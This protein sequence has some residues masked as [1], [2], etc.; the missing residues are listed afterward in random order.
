MLA[1]KL[2]KYILILSVFVAANVLCETIPGWEHESLKTPGKYNSGVMLDGIQVIYSSPVI[3]NIDND[4]SNG[5]ET[6]TVTSDGFVNA[7]NSAGQI[8]WKA[9]LPNSKCTLASSDD[10]GYSSPAIGEI[11]GDGIKYVVVGYGGVFAKDCG[12]GVVAINAKTGKRKWLFDLKKFTKKNKIP[13]PIGYA[14]FSTPVLGDIDNDG[15]LEIAFG[16]FDRNIY[17]LNFKGRPVWYYHAADTVW[18]SGAFHD[19]NGDGKQEL[20]IGTDI[21]ENKNYKPQTY[22]GG[23]VYAL[24]VKVKKKRTK[25]SNGSFK[26]VYVLLKYTFR[27]KRAYLWQTAFSQTIFSSPSLA[28]LIPENPG[29]E[30][31]VGTGCYFPESSKNKYGKEVSILSAATGEIIKKLKTSVCISSSP[32]IGD[33]NSDG[34]PDIALAVP[35]SSSVGGDGDSRIMAYD[36]RTGEQLWETI[37]LYYTMNDS[38]AGNFSSPIIADI[39]GNGSNE[40]IAANGEGIIIVNGVDGEQLTCAEQTCSTARLPT[41]GI[42]RNTPAVGDIDQD[43]DLELVAASGK[44][45]GKTKY[46]ML[47]GWTNLSTEI[48]SSPATGSSATPYSAPWPMFKQSPLRSSILK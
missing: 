5:L 47:Y 14:V 34:L 27:D 37:P 23:Y 8:L 35:G 24:K 17:V 4:I 31:A 22:N 48:F 7:I 26:K 3:D 45:Y 11:Y 43:G 15:K 28:D 13:V 41:G 16:S 29:L 39:D 6:V 33:L 40:V 32:A 46:G 20:I 10:K 9:S 30:I 25:M 12:G 36:P 2:A 19:V 18:S 44:S 42:M 21:T 38:W 1:R